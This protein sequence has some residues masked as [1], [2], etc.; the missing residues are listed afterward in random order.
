LCNFDKEKVRGTIGF[1]IGIEP[2]L[3]ETLKAAESVKMDSSG[4]ISL[5][6][7]PQVFSTESLESIETTNK[8]L[9]AGYGEIAFYFVAQKG[10]NP[11]DQKYLDI[12]EVAGKNN[13]VVMMH[14]DAR[15]ENSVGNAARKN[16]NV[17]FLIHGPEMEDPIINMMNNH[18]NVYYSIDAIL[19]RIPPSPGGLLYTSNNK[20]E[21]I[22]TFTENFDV[23]LNRAVKD[24]KEKIEQHP[25]RF[26]WGTDRAHK[27]TYDEEVSVLLEEFGRAFIA[28]LE[29]AV[30]KKFAY[31]NAERLIGMGGEGE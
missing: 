11:D 7:M 29:P 17:K 10:Q 3:E 8:G 26:M 15:Q 6:L 1:S 18:P 4:K 12:Y 28:R 21:F 13:L 24:W 31:E 22:L 2:L 23:L 27:W 5:F 30:Q 14:P 20:E 9:F 19:I 25:D 16:P